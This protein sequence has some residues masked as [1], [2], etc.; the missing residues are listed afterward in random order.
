MTCVWCRNTT[1]QIPDH[2][3]Y[4]NGDNFNLT[5]PEKWVITLN[6]YQRNNLLWLFQVMGDI[7]PFTFANNGDW[8]GEIPGMLQRPNGN[9]LENNDLS[10]STVEQMRSSVESWRDIIY[11]G[12]DPKKI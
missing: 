2:P 8:A 11:V 4:S 9:L 5:G 7:E 6:S 3:K 1:C 10:N 12:Y